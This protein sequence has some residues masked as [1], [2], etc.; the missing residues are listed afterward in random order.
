MKCSNCHTTIYDE[1][2]VKCPVCGE[3]L[4]EEVYEEIV[5]LNLLK[6]VVIVPFLV[7]NLFAIPLLIT[8]VMI[9]IAR[10]PM[11][12][13]DLLAFTAHYFLIV[14]GLIFISIFLLCILNNYQ[15]K[16]SNIMAMMSLVLFISSF[17][18]TF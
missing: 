16:V 11:E 6:S 4:Y 15:K 17:L 10:S 1:S 18:V 7:T 9:Y 14:A 5:D 2:L 13:M 3:K 12:S 8:Y